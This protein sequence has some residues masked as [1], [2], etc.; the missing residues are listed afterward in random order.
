[1][2]GRRRKHGKPWCR[3][4]AAEQKRTGCP[5]GPDCRHRDRCVVDTPQL[6]AELAEYARRFE[7][8]NPGL[9]AGA[10]RRRAGE[11]SFSQAVVDS[12]EQKTQAHDPYGR[13]VPAST[14]WNVLGVVN[15]WTELR[16]A[17][18]LMV[19]S[20]RQWS[21]YNGTLTIRDNPG[22]KTGCCGG[23]LNGAAG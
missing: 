8:Q 20:G 11:H 18:P 19:A 16:I 21:F 15:N 9:V 4:G 1:M 6:A 23:S 22:M 13:G 14:I 17:D 12:L 7:R 10:R 5:G 3:A 2:S